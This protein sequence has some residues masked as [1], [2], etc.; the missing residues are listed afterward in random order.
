M[1]QSRDSEVLAVVDQ[2]E[3]KMGPSF[4]TSWVKVVLFERLGQKDK[5]F[6]EIKKNK[7]FVPYARRSL[8]VLIPFLN[9]IKD[10]E[11]KSQFLRR[12]TEFHPK[13]VLFQ[14]QLSRFLAEKKQ[15]GQI[16]SIIEGLSNVTRSKKGPL[17]DIA[18]RCF[19]KLGQF[20]EATYHFKELTLA[21]PK[22]WRSFFNYGDSLERQGQ[23]NEARA[24]FEA[25]LKLNPPA[26]FHDKIRKKI[27]STSR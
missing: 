10:E 9:N 1:R 21:K 25:A 27:S 24:N 4:L 6:L 2:L 18:G 8:R 11:I 15:C 20:T 5:F 23:L 3:R 16:G 7:I 14:W 19:M 17:F 13:N 22:D 12:L 26:E